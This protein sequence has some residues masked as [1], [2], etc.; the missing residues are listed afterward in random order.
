[1]KKSMFLHLFYIFFGVKQC[2][3][4]Y[5]FITLHLIC[6]ACAVKSTRQPHIQEGV[7]VSCSFSLK[8]GKL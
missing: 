7:F 8:S 4:A 5:F 1:M 3:I 2:K 6:G